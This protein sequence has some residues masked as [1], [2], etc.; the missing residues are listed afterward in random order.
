MQSEPGA[1]EQRAYQRPTKV[2]YRVKEPRR[3]PLEPVEDTLIKF[4]KVS[5]AVEG[6]NFAKN[7]LEIINQ[8]RSSTVIGCPAKRIN[9][10]SKVTRTNR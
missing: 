10:V 5:M 2:I 1:A 9:F 6:I 3:L 4:I 8:F 7:L